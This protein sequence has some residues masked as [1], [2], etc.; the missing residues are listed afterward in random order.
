[1]RD[2][3][4]KINTLR[5][6]TATATLRVNAATIGMIQRGELPKGDPLPVARVAAIQA[7]KGTD[8]IIPYCHPVP[9]DHVD[10]RFEMTDECI[11]I[12]VGVKAIYRTGVE[13]E[14]LTAASVA[15]L[16]IYDMSKMVDEDMEITGVRLVSKRGG[17]SDFTPSVAGRRAAVVVISDSV[18]AGHTE[19][20]SGATICEGLIGRGFDVTVRDVVPDDTAAIETAVRECV[21]DSGVDVVITTGG[22]GLG[23]RDVTPEAVAGLIERPLPAIGEA[24]RAFGQQR[25]PTAMLSRSCAGIRGNAL[26][27]CLPGAVAA[28]EESMA[29][30]LPAIGHVFAILAGGRH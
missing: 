15:A 23:P 6:A 17:K 5:I 25:I 1:M 18:A 11:T 28:V 7:A 30:V 19:D 9:V 16:T 27:I 10:V 26:I 8:R 4:N 29:V 20:R 24:L 13:M 2:V 21:D 3:S 12:N 14:A 22:T